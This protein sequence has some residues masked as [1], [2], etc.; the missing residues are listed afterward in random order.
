MPELLDWHEHYLLEDYR[1]DYRTAVLAWLQTDTR[2]HTVTE[3]L[4]MLFPQYSPQVGKTEHA[5]SPQDD[6]YEWTAEDRRVFDRIVA[7]LPAE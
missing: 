4:H 2:K 7:S 5:P 6:V 1:E 3:V